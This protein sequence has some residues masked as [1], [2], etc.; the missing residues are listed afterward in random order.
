MTIPPSQ[1][2]LERVNQQISAEIH[3][4]QDGSAMVHLDVLLAQL[5]AAGECLRT[6]DL[7]NDPDAVSRQDEFRENLEHLAAVLPSMHDRLLVDRARL[8]RARSHLN[9]ALTWA[10]SFSGRQNGK[11]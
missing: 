9:G 5:I 11:Y 7:Q 10:N 8:E 2:E 1:D 4:F 3:R 6:L